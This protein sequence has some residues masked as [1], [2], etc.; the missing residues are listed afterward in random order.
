[1]IKN[2]TRLLCLFVAITFCSIATAQTYSVFEQLL[3]VNKTWANQPDVDFRL[4]MQPAAVLPEKSL[5]Q[6]HLQET[7]KLLRQRKRNGQTIAQWA[8]RLKNLD[9]LHQY[10]L[11][12]VF[13]INNKHAGRQPYF[14]DDWGTYCAVGYLMKESGAGNMAKD[15]HDS[16]NFSYLADIQHPDLNEWAANSGLSFA[17]LALIQPSYSGDWPSSIIEMHY[18]NTGVDVGEYIEVHQGS[19]LAGF[20]ANSIGF[21]DY[22]GTLYKTLLFSQMQLISSYVGNS[23]YSYSFPAGES[24]ADSGKVVLFKSIPAAGDTFCV[25][26]YNASGIQLRD[27]FFSQTRNFSIVENEATPV[28][29]SLTFCGLYYSTWNTTVQPATVGT[30]NPC[31]TSA[32]P[33]T[34]LSFDYKLNNNTVQLDWKTASE[35]NTSHFEIERSMNG[36][37]F[38]VIG[39]LAAA[40]NSSNTRNYTF[41]D[42]TPQYT[43]HYRLRQIDKDGKSSYSAMLF[44]K[45]QAASPL[46]VIENPVK[47]KLTLLVSSDQANASDIT[48]F[49]FSGRQ[50]LNA[51]SK[52]GYQYI[53]VSG[54]SAGKYLITLRT[55]NGQ[56]YSSQFIKQ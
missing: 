13:P 14:I 34:L 11:A 8:N 39:Q 25:T 47:T 54:L 2:F 10:W 5:V 33:L 26:T 22:A 29:S 16:Q 15:I 41:T 1:M 18:N 50:I 49:D 28:G 37:D 52:A 32:L 46:T 12:G 35:T 20:R 3:A 24:F 51:V 30:I 43:N 31:T 27:F 17:E 40:G 9:V 7:E 56:T 36:T 23:Y 38:K 4:K 42:A 45:I 6:L 19:G 21:Y 48:I 53:N 55:R 44:V